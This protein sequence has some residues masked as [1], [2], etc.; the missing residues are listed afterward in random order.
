MN[1]N[2][3]A[4]EGNIGAGKT[5]L[6]KMVAQ[7][8]NG[9]LLLEEFAE[10][11]FLPKFYEQPDRHAFSVEL[12]FLADRFHQL[13]RN[14]GNPSLFH[15]V[16]VSDYYI[17]KSLIFSGATLQD[18]E[19]D[20]FKRLFDIMFASAPKPD[21]VVYL[22]MDVDR[23]LSNIKKRGRPYEQEI[24]ATYLEKIQQRYLQFIRQQ[25]DM[26]TLIMDINALDFVENSKDFNTL[27]EIMQQ[28]Y[29]PGVHTHIVKP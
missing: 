22:Y 3:I 14:L 7:H 27:L 11:P 16:T 2:F 4:I 28:D 20:L 15:E 21:L 1:R 26:T 25:P 24:E 10:N 23:L 17:A 6:A 19:Y 8:W 29:A 18:D 12:Y 5:T 9:R 13:Q